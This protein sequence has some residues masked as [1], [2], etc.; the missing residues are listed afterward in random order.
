MNFPFQKLEMKTARYKDRI[1]VIQKD[2]EQLII[3]QVKGKVY[4]PE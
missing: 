3:D 2:A 4:H 1:E